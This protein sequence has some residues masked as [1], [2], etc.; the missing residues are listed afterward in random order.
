MNNLNIF[1]VLAAEPIYGWI[2]IAFGTSV[3]LILGLLAGCLI[4]FKIKLKAEEQ[5]LGTTHKLLHEV[6]THVREGIGI[7]DEHE[8]VEF[9]NPAFAAIFGFEQEEMTGQ[10]ILDFLPSS[11]RDLVLGQTAR[12][13][14]G[15]HDTYDMNIET[16]SG[17]IRTIRVSVTPRFDEQGKYIG[18]FGALQDITTEKVTKDA[19]KKS[20]E[21]KEHLIKEI[22]HRVKNNLLMVSSLLNLK[23]S[24]AGDDE[25]FSDI[26]N[27][28]NAIRLVHEKLHQNDDVSKIDFGAYAEDLLESIFSSFTSKPVKLENR[29]GSFSLSAKSAVTLGIIT[30]EIATNAIKHGFNGEEEAKFTIDMYNENPGEGCV[31]TMSNSGRRFPDGTAP[32]R[33][34][35]LGLRLIYALT[36]QLGGAVEL[37][38]DPVTTFIMRFPGQL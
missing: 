19:L 17:E 31:V 25:L 3:A 12:R 32:S 33:A 24:E 38:R 34:N 2:G 20:L 22:N 30:N 36:S 5:K 28:I 10:S 29:I 11:D 7:V 26:Q 23:A 27:Q 14:T 6:V 18:A 15:K 37:Q 21:E 1:A 35:S 8:R 16:V 4:N 13:K 9:C